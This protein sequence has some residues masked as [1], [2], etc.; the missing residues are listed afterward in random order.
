MNILYI[1]YPVTDDA[2]PHQSMAA[3]TL[4]KMGQHIDYM[5]WGDQRRPN[6]LDDFTNIKYHIVLKKG[7]KSALS[8]SISIFTYIFTRKP[9]LIYIQGAQ[10]TPFVLWL[11]I[12]R[13]I[14]VVYHTQD[15]LGPGQHFFYELCEKLIARRADYVISNEPNRA[16]FMAS[17]YRLNNFPEVI[18][19]SLPQWW[20]VPERSKELRNKLLKQ[21]GLNDSSSPR[22]I[23]AGGGYDEGR[24]SPELLNAFSQLPMNYALIF[25]GMKEGSAAFKACKNHM[26]KHNIT[27]RVIFLERLSY[28]ELLKI[29]AA[30]DI[31]IL[32]YPNNG[33]GHYYQAPGRLTEYLRCGLSIVTSNFPGLELLFLK[34]GLGAVADP[35]SPESIKKSIQSVG[36]VTEDELVMNR[37]RL[38]HKSYNELHYDKQA[39]PIL[40]KIVQ[41]IN[42]SKQMV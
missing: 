21:S 40:S 12:Y 24:M 16:R 19:T 28:S 6:W 18:R 27:E 30:C 3:F 22:L 8:F 39:V 31:G 23:V 37:N 42:D 34:H 33:V 26:Q 41:E 4:A 11:I 9:N 10:Q 35:Y 14:P 1:S 5:G 38:I 2:A 20:A 36:N 17:S 15:Y 7:I 25:T 32:L 13:N 29:Y